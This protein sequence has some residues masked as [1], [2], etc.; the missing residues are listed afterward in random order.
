MKYFN[1]VAAVLLSLLYLSGRI[2]PTEKFN[3]WATSFIIPI[4]LGLNILLMLFSLLLRKKSSLYYLIALA[5]GSPYLLNTVGMKYLLKGEA[6]TSGQLN[7]MSY[8]LGGFRT[9]SAKDGKDDDRRLFTDWI[10][11]DHADVIC[12]Q[13]F[14]TLPWSEHFNIIKRLDQKKAHYYFSREKETSH[15]SYSIGGTL[16]VS[17]FPIISQ[18]DIFYST[19]G[20]NRASYADIVIRED[21]IRII[22]VHLESMGL[23]ITPRNLVNPDKARS[24]VM[25]ILRKLKVGTFERSEQN[26]KLVAF[27]DASPYPVICAGD[28]NDLPYTYSYQLLKSRMKNSFEESGKGFGFTYGGRLLRML[29]ID[30]QFYT[31]PIK[32]TEFRTL[33]EIKFSDHYPIRGEYQ[34]VH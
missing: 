25:T 30:N 9:Y 1:F 28:F 33:Y 4:G 16:I 22:N 8:N 23:V 24:S 20:F 10:L 18:G 14:E 21:T 6:S 12:Y 32:S 17:K 5:I 29:R 27:I 19:N 31:P 34:I 26:K 2:P 7:V 15:S 11:R 13:E 3:L